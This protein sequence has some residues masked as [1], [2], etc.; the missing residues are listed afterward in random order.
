[1]RVAAVCWMVTLAGCGRLGFEPIT[2]AEPDSQFAAVA[3]PAG[4]QA[5]DLGRT[6]DG[7]LYA[8]IGSAYAVR[9]IDGGQTW[10][11]CAALRT[12][13]MNLFVD[14]ELGTV[15]VGDRYAG[16]LVASDDRCATWRDLAVPEY[17]GAIAMLGADVLVG[18][19]S[20]AWRLGAGVWTRF[21]TPFDGRRVS[22]IAVDPSGSRVLV[23][24]DA[25]VARSTN[26]GATWTIANTGL[27]GLGVTFL[28]LDP[29]R[30]DRA[31][32]QASSQLYHSIDGGLSWSYSSYGGYGVAIDPSDA[33]F[34]VFSAWTTGLNISNDGA[35]TFATADRRSAQMHK[36]TVSKLVFGPSSQLFAATNRGL[37][38][39]TDHGLDWRELGDL[40]AWTV[41][42]I[43]IDDAGALFL[44]TPSGV[45]R[46]ADDGA[47]WTEHSA[48]FPIDSNTPSVIVHPS[49]PRTVLTA[50]A[51][52]ITRSDDGGLSFSPLWTAA[53]ADG[54][55]L[56]SLH[57]AGDGLVVGTWGGVVTADASWSTFTHHDIAGKQEFVNDAV[58]LDA[59][60][61]KLIAGGAQIWYSS[62]GGATWAPT[63]PA[64]QGARCFAKLAGDTML[65]CTNDG[66]LIAATPSGPWSPTTL[67]HSTD[68]L[69]V[70]DELVIAAT[71]RGVFLS[72]DTGST[73]NPLVGLE[74]R[75]PISLAIDESLRL[76]VGTRGHGL[77]VT[78]L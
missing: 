4:A 56:N 30:P 57:A 10:T 8:V 74:S 59:T 17:A 41:H 19:D 14:R 25:G 7:I 36:A 22:A 42:S 63:G 66:V 15:Y 18:G 12:L 21:A 75:Y 78:Q 13:T 11:P 39:A 49:A 43:A 27:T 6:A 32:L 76:Y 3:L 31:V 9:S 47:T 40:S 35:I 23:G 29:V 24:S 34:V 50:T 2:R 53:G 67:T 46:S 71:D 69:L 70:S 45:L 60:G 54:F 44:G 1:M 68:A 51:G 73:W 52:V 65:A 58:A 20:G 77:F 55:N 64:G 28:A 61:L 26:G 37:F 62:D 38:Y 5:T 16:T 48:G 33:D 72:R